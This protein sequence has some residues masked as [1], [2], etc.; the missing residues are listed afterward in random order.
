MKHLICAA[1]ILAPLSVPL[2]AMADED[3]PIR[4]ESKIVGDKEQPSVSYFVPWQDASGVDRLYQ[5]VEDRYD[6]SLDTIDRDVML[7]SM[8]IYDEMN[9]ENNP[10]PQ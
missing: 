1:L 2:S 9:L 7:R 3:E 4:L 10:A 6:D 5:N 8:R